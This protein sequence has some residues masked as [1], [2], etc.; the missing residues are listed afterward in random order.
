MESKKKKGT[1]GS[2]QRMTSYLLNFVKPVNDSKLFAGL[3]IITLN[4]GSRYVNMN[5]P[6][7]IES[8]LKYTFSRNILVFAICWM[9]TKE[10]LTALFLTVLFALVMDHLLNDESPYC[11]LPESFTDYHRELYDNSGNL[12]I[13]SSGGDINIQFKVD[14]ENTNNPS[15]RPDFQWHGDLPNWTFGKSDGTLGFSSFMYK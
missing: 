8:Y 9:G 11:C 12:Q 13:D 10:V 5:L 15:G 1:E 14:I 3:I 7:P 4:I 2:F 6:K